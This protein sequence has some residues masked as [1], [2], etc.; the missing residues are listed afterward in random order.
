[1]Y[2]IGELAFGRPTR[3]TA[4]S[5]MGEPGIINVE[6]ESDLSGETHD[7]GM[8]IIA[9]FLGRIFAQEYPLS[10]SV[11]ITFEQNYTG[12]DGDSASSTELY[13]VLSSLSGYPI[14]Q[15]IAVTGS[16]NQ[17]GQ[18]QS[19][20]GVNE[21]IEGFF[22]VCAGRGLTGDQGV[23]IPASNVNNLM[24]RKD[25]V[26]AVTQR[27]FHIWQVSTI[28]QGIE[29]LTGVPAGQAGDNG[30]FPPDTVFG[31]VQAKLKKFHDRSILKS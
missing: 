18:I 21:K 10:V 12:V 11:S 27:R 24:L 17:K 14:R 20:G 15:G 16:V 5:Y 6:R 8:M 3:I 22:D 31:A 19:I 28:D 29:V 25:V 30:Q 1:V 7:K 4:E 23:M 9:G 13:A 26:D 2:Q